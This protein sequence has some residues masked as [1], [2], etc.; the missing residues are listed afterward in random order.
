MYGVQFNAVHPAGRDIF[1]ESSWS[2]LCHAQRAKRPRGLHRY[3]AI[4]GIWE[5]TPCT[6]FTTKNYGREVEEQKSLLREMLTS[7]DDADNYETRL[8]QLAVDMRKDGVDFS[9]CRISYVVDLRETSGH[10]TVQKAQSG[11]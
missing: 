6:V 9:E 7:L 4:S 5:C 2:P 1:V 3:I 11:T 8:L 10:D